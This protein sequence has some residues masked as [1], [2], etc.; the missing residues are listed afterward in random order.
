MFVR[1]AVFPTYKYVKE[2]NDNKQRLQ[3]FENVL[4]RIYKK[5]QIE[6]EHDKKRYREHIVIIL[7]KQIQ[8][9]RDN[10]IRRMKDKYLNKSKTAGELL[11]VNK[12]MQF[13]HIPT[14]DI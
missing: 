13:H 7:Y 8:T 1:D 11:R 4:N 9:H 2:F 10:V 3:S 5:L 12:K 14:S 6:T